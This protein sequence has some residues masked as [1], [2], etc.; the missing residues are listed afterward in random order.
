LILLLQAL[1]ALGYALAAHLASLWQHDG[2]ALLA[3]GLLVAMLL[4]EPLLHRRWWAWL[5]LPLAGWGAWWLYAAGHA[6]VPLLLVPVV[7]VLGVAWLFARTLRAGS[8]PLISR[9]VIG[10]EGGDALA[11]S[12]DLQRYA[13]NLT[14]AWAAV[15]L[16]MAAANLVLAMLASPGGLLESIGATPPW[17]I[18]RAQWSWFANLLNYGVV[19]GFFAA[20]FSVRQRRFPGRYRNFLDFARKLAALEPAFWRSLLR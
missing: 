12:P 14:A 18:T 10:L 13:R 1:L 4:V 19:G 16:A 15:L 11:V 17:P 8:V 6:A 20:E 5:L 2:L 9:I 3:L 7:F